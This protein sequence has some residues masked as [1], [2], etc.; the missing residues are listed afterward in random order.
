M[1]FNTIKKWKTFNMG[2]PWN[3]NEFLASTTLSVLLTAQKQ[4]LLPVTPSPPSCWQLVSLSFTFP[5]YKYQLLS[6]FFSKAPQ[7]PAKAAF[8]PEL[9]ES[10]SP[11]A[12]L[13]RHLRMSRELILRRGLQS[14][15]FKEGTCTFV[16]DL[17]LL[18]IGLHKLCCLLRHHSHY[19]L[20]LPQSLT[21]I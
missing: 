20:R 3:C 1:V 6:D 5:P 14:E 9:W 4:V 19:I 13:T 2:C 7:N 21:N 8:C 17:H 11:P 12:D 18:Y 16:Y 15:L 10:R